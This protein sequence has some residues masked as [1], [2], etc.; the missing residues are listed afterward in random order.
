[1]ANE[2]LDDVKAPLNQGDILSALN[3]DDSDSEVSKD[4]EIKLEEKPDKSEDKD[5][6]EPSPEVELEDKTEDED[7]LKVE[8]DDELEFQDVPKRQEILA[9]FPDI[10]KK[11]PGIQSALYREDKYTRI[12]PSIKEA[13]TAKD[14]LVTFGRIENDL[15][16]GNIGNL[17][18]TVK[19]TDS[20]AFNKISGTLLQTLNAVDKEA[21]FGTVNHVLQHAITG[22]F[23]AG[24]DMAGED[25]EQLQIAAQLLNKFLYGSTNIKEP[26][27]QKEEKPDPREE[28]LKARETEFQKNQLDIAVNDVTSKTNNVI[29]NAVTKYIDPKGLMGD[30]VKKTAIKDVIAAI[31]SEISDDKRFRQNLDLLWMDAAKNN[32]SSESKDRIRKAILKKV[33]SVI[34]GH[35]K[36]VRADAIKGSKSSN[37]NGS[38][39]RNRTN[40]DDDNEPVKRRTAPP[41][42]NRSSSRNEK[43]SRI[44][45]VRD[46]MKFLE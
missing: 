15:L 20:K 12:F 19:Q 34:P 13:E 1:M 36:K 4:D 11:F 27:A 32:Y 39:S 35:V 25:G 17:L 30:Y 29:K 7:E 22:A 33:Q 46:V 23:K 24:K 42:N 44:G 41:Q 6:E 16:S 10:F 9:A 40:D 5:E 43:P 28:Q 3:E 26:E 31:D 37:S 21:Y 14:R 8:D 2:I 18:A 45:S 38:S